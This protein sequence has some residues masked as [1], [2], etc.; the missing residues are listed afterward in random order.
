MDKPYDFKALM[1]KIIALIKQET[2]IDCFIEGGMGPQQPYPFF[3]Y[4][5][6]PYIPIDIT[7]NVDYEE[8]EAEIN[9]TAHSKSANESYTF[10]NQLRKIFETQSMDYLGDENDFGVVGTSEVESSDNVI[11]IQ[12]E[13]RTEFT[14]RLRLLDTFQDKINTIDDVGINGTNLSEK[15]DYKKRIGGI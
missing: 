11:T 13:R 14:V 4:Q 5:V 6:K 15:D 10:G 8:F 1:I 9:F 12:V 2:G 3:T 7:D